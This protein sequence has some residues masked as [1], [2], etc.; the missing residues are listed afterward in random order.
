MHV[1][2]GRNY[3]TGSYDYAMSISQFGAGKIQPGPSAGLV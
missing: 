2:P 1:S 3:V